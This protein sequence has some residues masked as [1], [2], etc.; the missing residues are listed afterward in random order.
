MTGIYF[1]HPSDVDH[2]ILKNMKFNNPSSVT[3]ARYGARGMNLLNL[4]VP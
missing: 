3:L 1:L 2:D 4:L